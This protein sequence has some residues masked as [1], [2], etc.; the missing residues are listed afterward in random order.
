MINFT[1]LNIPDRTF[2]NSDVGT[3]KTP[4]LPY[5]YSYDCTY[6]AVPRDTLITTDIPEKIDKNK[7]N[8]YDIYDVQTGTQQSISDKKKVISILKFFGLSSLATAAAFVFAKSRPWYLKIAGGI[9]TG[10]LLT[11]IRDA[12]SGNK[13]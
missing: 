10:G 9:V 4:S 2:V 7:Y 12:L 1:R 6:D 5:L 3:D 13:S 8:S 11:L